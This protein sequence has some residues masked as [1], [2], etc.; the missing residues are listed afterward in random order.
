MK[1]HGSKE[2]F[3][4]QYVVEGSGE[5]PIDMLRYDRSCPATEAD[6]HKI[7]REGVR[8]I[9]L[10]RFSQGNAS[11]NADRWESFRWKILATRYWDG[12]GEGDLDRL[13]D[14][15]EV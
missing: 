9:T 14:S 6:A 8:R 5:F 2:F 10:L 13:Q 12:S 15:S 3:E 4:I 1:Q 7:S 11:P